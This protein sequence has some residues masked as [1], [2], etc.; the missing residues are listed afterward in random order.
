MALFI[1]RVSVVINIT[2]KVAYLVFRAH[3]TWIMVFHMVSGL[4]A[5]Q[6]EVLV[7]VGP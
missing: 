4:C 6:E 5:D 1:S 2:D 3:G 7:I